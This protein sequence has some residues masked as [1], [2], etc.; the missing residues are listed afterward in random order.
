MKVRSSRCSYR[1]MLRHELTAETH[2]DMLIFKD[3]RWM[4]KGETQLQ[5]YYCYW[6]ESIKSTG[7]RMSS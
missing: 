6:Q 7:S 3:D 2:E 5:V 4:G 1:K